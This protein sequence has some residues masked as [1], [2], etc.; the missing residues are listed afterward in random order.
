MKATVVRLVCVAPKTTFSHCT[1][2]TSLTW[3]T[4]SPPLIITRPPPPASAL[5]PSAAGRMGSSTTTSV[6][7]M[8]GASKV[9]AYKCPKR[10]VPVTE[11]SPS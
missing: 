4:R 3:K 9:S 8:I 6:V 10:P 11:R 1:V 7:L 2:P 5:A